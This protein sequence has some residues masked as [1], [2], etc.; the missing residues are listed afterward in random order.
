MVTEHITQLLAYPGSTQVIEVGQGHRQL[1]TAAIADNSPLCGLPLQALWRQP[2]DPRCIHVS[3]GY[4]PASPSDPLQTND[5]ITFLAPPSQAYSWTQQCQPKQGPMKKIMIAG[6]SDLGY[7]LAHHLQHN[8]QVRLIEK[9]P[10]RCQY[11]AEKLSKVSVLLGD[12]TDHTL[13]QQESIETQHCFCS[14]T[15]DDEDNILAAIQAKHLGCQNALALI[16]RSYYIPLLQNS[17]IDTV[18]SPQKV[19]VSALLPHARPPAVH[20]V[21]RLQHHPGEIIELTLD[22]PLSQWEDRVFSENLFPHPHTLLGILQHG[23]FY[24]K[25]PFPSLLPDDRIWLFIPDPSK[26]HLLNTSS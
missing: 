4:H 20:N 25:P 2:N 14:L 22:T 3:R 15:G 23:R 1:I 18:L 9:D 13:M 12:A 24:D 6:G 21:Y 11:V 5:L 8:H 17:L 10:A 19:L 26:T 16:D 7:T